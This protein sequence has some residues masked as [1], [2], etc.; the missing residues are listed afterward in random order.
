MNN[1]KNTIFFANR[2]RYILIEFVIPQ[3]YTNLKKV[4][5]INN[6]FITY[7]NLYSIQFKI[8]AKIMFF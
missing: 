5:K 6:L 1:S 3:K 2:H 8:F 4:R 7:N